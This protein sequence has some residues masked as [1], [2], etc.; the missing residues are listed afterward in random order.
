[1]P[2]INGKDTKGMFYKW[3]KTG[4][5]YH[6]QSHNSVARAKAKNQAIRQAIAIKYHKGRGGTSSRQVQP[7]YN[8]NIYQ[9]A[10]TEYTRLEAIRKNLVREW[11]I[12]HS[13]VLNTPDHMVAKVAQFEAMEAAKQAELNNVINRLKVI[14]CF[15]VSMS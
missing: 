2:L 12:I 14:R 4:H 11:N 9:K 6:Y 8:E 7:I 10:K 13:L 3:G 15:W 5:K 1:M